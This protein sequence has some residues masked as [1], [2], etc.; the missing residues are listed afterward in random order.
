MTDDSFLGRMARRSRER[1][2][3]ARAQESEAT[4]RARA[5]ATAHPPRL[6]LGEFGVIAELKLRSPAAGSLAEPGFDLGARLTA[7][8][9]GGA[10][11][12]SILTEPD[13]FKGDLAHLQ[14]A[15]SILQEHDTPVMR[16]DF[17]TEPYQILEARAAGASGVLV[18]VTMLNDEETEALLA[19]ARDCGL[20]V[21]LEAFDVGDLRR[22]AGLTGPWLAPE[23][24][25]VLCGV[26]CRDLKTL[27]V[28][29]G[30][31]RSLVE[32]LPAGL[33]AVAESGIL[34]I[35][36]V[37]SVAQMGYQGA[38]VG[39]ALMRSRQ[40]SQTVAELTKT[41]TQRY[42]KRRSCS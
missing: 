30:R 17:L 26:N 19:C 35:E 14:E 34:G 33:T 12:I 18:I 20:F 2:L 9:S 16:K 25:P 3:R 11:A 8:A 4:L 6:T 36:E 31:F 42:E 37:H 39:S 1:T 23:Q 38:L 29:F 7:Y 28:D 24:A 13:E 41:G 15:A 5:M 21:L 22:I 32:H 40:P 27:A 10:M